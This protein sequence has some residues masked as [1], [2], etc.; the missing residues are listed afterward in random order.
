MGFGEG[1]AGDHVSEAGIAGAV[2]AKVTA[3][4]ARAT[5][6]WVFARYESIRARLPRAAFA[7]GSDVI[8][9]LGALEERFDAYLFDSFGVLN[10]GDTPIAGAQERLARLRDLGKHVVILT[11]A[12]TPAAADLVAKYDRMG[13]AVPAAQI[14]SSRAVLATHMAPYGPDWRWSV[15]APEASRIAELPGRAQPFDRD[16]AGAADGFVFLSS[17]GWSVDR[18]DLLVEALRASKRPFLIGNPDLVAPRENALSL[19]PGAYAHDVADRT[20][21][22]PD[23]FGKPFTNA[24]AAALKALPPDLPRDRI[25]MV[26][27]TLHTDILGAAACGIASLLVTEHGVLRDLDIAACIAA[28]GIHPSYIAP[29]I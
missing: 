26:G 8:P 14:V 6:D 24:F 25:L 21:I 7:P 16:S 17:Q 3:L 11:N 12:A 23:F 4:P 28:A 27:D 20:G 5:P 1:A 10:V 13:F 29:H 22:A 2:T 18:Q 19:E 15:I 9:D